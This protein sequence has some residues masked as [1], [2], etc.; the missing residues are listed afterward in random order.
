SPVRLAHGSRIRIGN[1]LIEVRLPSGSTTQPR[2]NEAAYPK[3]LA[4][5]GELVFLRPDGSDGLH[6][7][8][9]RKIVIGRGGP[10]D[11]PVDVPLLDSNVSR[12]HAAIGPGSH[13]LKLKNLSQTDG[14]FVEI[15]KTHVL[16]EG[17]CFRLGENLWQ[18]VQYR[19]PT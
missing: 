1:Y 15:K 10:D 8:L 5:L 7:P 14:T 19:R 16:V 2:P 3:D 12:K 17:D 18:M 4:A 9:L 6:F 11:D 13:G